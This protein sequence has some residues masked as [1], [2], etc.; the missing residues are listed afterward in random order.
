M[1]SVKLRRGIQ[2]F[3]DIDHNE[4]TTLPAGIFDQL[5]YLQKL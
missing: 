2:L 4:I 5:V 1:K 3:R